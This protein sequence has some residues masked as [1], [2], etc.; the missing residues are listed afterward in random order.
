MSLAFHN[1]ER[2]EQIETNRLTFSFTDNELESFDQFFDPE[3]QDIHIE[4][5][6]G[7][8]NANIIDIIRHRDVQ[9]SS[10]INIY[11]SLTIH[12]H[13]ADTKLSI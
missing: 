12:F 2:M 4:T 11:F 13:E 6:T 5:E 1:Q 10:A 8:V 9:Q 3:I 7:K